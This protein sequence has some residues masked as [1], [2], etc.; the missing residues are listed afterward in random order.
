MNQS[1]KAPIKK[2]NYTAIPY[3]VEQGRGVQGSACFENR[4]PAI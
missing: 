1:I 3:R 2:F 4:L